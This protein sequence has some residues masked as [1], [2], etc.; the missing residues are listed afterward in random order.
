MLDKMADDGAIV[1]E[2]DVTP[3]RERSE[4][5]V[6]KLESEGFWP[7]GLWAEIG[8]CKWPATS[9]TSLPRMLLG[10]RKAKYA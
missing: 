2:I 6:E 10:S 8:G 3:L 5:A 1:T 7:K 4:V 9:A